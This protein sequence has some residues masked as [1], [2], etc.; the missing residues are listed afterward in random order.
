MVQMNYSEEARPVLVAIYEASAETRDVE[1][2]RV[3]E[4]LGRDYDDRDTDE[5]LFALKREGYIEGYRG[6]GYG[7]WSLLRLE[8]PGLQEIA[9]WPVTPGANYGAKFLDE[10][11]RKIADAADADERSRLEKLRETAVKVGTGVITGVLTDMA[12]RGL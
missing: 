5:A 3:N 9:G 6:G 11:E 1:S 12:N 7:S 4:L 10:L 2:D 8:G